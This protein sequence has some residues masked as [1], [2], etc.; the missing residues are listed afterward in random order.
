MELDTASGGVSGRGVAP[1]S[2]PGGS[3]RLAD[4]LVFDFDGGEAGAA[5]AAP[6]RRRAAGATYWAL[7]LRSC[8]FP[9]Q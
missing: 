6:G 2:Q 7:T 8:I 1:E 4:D 5:D 3:G 9:S